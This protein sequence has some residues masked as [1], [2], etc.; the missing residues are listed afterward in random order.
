MIMKRSYF[1]SIGNLPDKIKSLAKN[2][3]FLLVLIM[4]IAFSL[5]FGNLGEKTLYGDEILSLNIV[6]HYQHQPAEMIAYLQEIEIHPPLYYLMLDY[7]LDLTGLDD[8]S[9]K[10]LSAI[11]GLAMVFSV[12]FVSKNLFSSNRIG[13]TAAFITSILPMQIE[14][15]MQAR[16][17]IIYCFIGLW[18]VFFLWRYFESGKIR[19][20]ALYCLSALVGLYLHYS[21]AFILIAS[22]SYYF[23]MAAS[24]QLGKKE[25]TRW[26]FSMTAIFLGFYW[27]LKY[28]LYKYF[29]QR[30]ILFNMDLRAS[31]DSLKNTN[32]FGTTMNQLIWTDVI[33]EHGYVEVFA[34]LF[35]KIFILGVIIY[36]IMYL[37]RDSEGRSL[38]LKKICY[39]GW[40]LVVPLIIY[41]F[42]PQSIG[43]TDI[44]E[45][46]L[47]LGSVIIAILLAVLAD[48]LGKKTRL[49]FFILFFA[50]VAI[51]DSKIVFENMYLRLGCRAENLSAMITG[52][53]RPG[54]LVVLYYGHQ[55]ANLN[56]FL[57]EKIETVSFYPVW[58]LDWQSDYLASRDTLGLIENE[59]QLRIDHGNDQDKEKKIEYLLGK[60]SPTRIWLITR[61][62]HEQF[63]PLWLFNHGWKK[64]DLSKNTCK[65]V[66]L[67]EKK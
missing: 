29:L 61:D 2:E 46:H 37:D 42:S 50:S 26:L 54:D 1:E 9:A 45:R 40:L 48:R 41:F 39:F 35:T 53:Y 55:R 6:K 30:S 49:L 60:H 28:F 27:W 16:P 14:Y 47:I 57:P 23:F 24:K 44:N 13:L 3:F 34:I 4:L 15:S 25:M 62:V 36:F 8:Y 38:Y 20:L 10:L 12:Y 52:N 64:D 21:F 65:Y 66:E 17:Y 18:H 58:L 67:F 7:W 31:I 32:F 22:T 43:Y 19:N 51:Y 59:L 56:H 33:N 63:F 11:F 5:R